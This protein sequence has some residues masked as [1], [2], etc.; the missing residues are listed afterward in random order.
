VPIGNN[1]KTD[2]KVQIFLAKPTDL[3][4]GIFG[5][6]GYAPDPTIWNR[7]PC[8]FSQ[9]KSTL[10]PRRGSQEISHGPQADQRSANRKP[11]KRYAFVHNLCID[12]TI[13]PSV[14]RAISEAGT[15]L[16][17]AMHGIAP[18]PVHE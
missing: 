8:L 10:C 7:Q 9:C 1:V 11:S 3:I 6:Q 13:R 14:A 17:R 2:F 4:C 12:F 18:T 16:H 15:S 5:H